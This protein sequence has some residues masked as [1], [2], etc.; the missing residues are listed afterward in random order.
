VR[1]RL[2]RATA[3]VELRKIIA[4]VE[5]GVWQKPTRREAVRSIA[6]AQIP[7][8]DDYIEYWLTARFHGVLGEKPLKTNTRSD[9]R[10]RAGHLKRFFGRYRLYEID[11]DLCLAF[12]THKLREAEELREA[13]RAGA[14]LRDARNHRLAPLG[15]ASLKKL[16]AMLAAVLEDAVEDGHL[17]ANPARSRRLRIRVPKPRRTF[18]EIDELACLEDIARAQ[19]PPL[20]L[21]RQAAMAA[22]TGSTR[23]A[24]A[25]A[26]SEGKSQ[27][28]IVRELGLAKGSVSYHLKRLNLGA[29]KYVGRGAI[30][31]TLG[32]SGVRVSELCNL[33]IHQLR[34]HDPEQARFLIADAKTETGVRA[35]EMS[36]ALVEVIL[37]H[38]DRLRRYGRSTTPESHLFQNDEGGRMR[39]HAVGKI[40]A[41]AA[42]AASEVTCKQGLPALPHT[43]PHSMRRTYI[44][45]ALLANNFDVVWVMKQVGHAN[46]KM[47]LEIYAQLQQR[48]RRE[49]G[50]KFDALVRNAHEQLATR[51][52]TPPQQSIGSAIGS[53]TSDARPRT[54]RKRRQHRDQKARISRRSVRLR[55]SGLNPG[56]HDFQ[57]CALPTELSR[58][59]GRSVTI[60]SAR[61]SHPLSRQRRDPR[62]PGTAAGRS[63]GRPRPAS[64]R[65]ISRGAGA[66]RWRRRSGRPCRAPARRRPP[67]RC[68]R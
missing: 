28:A 38:I 59:C 44:S 23:A 21:F 53:A 7:L 52:K 48:A 40:L 56:H 24:V 10:W 12:K 37:G 49:N 30:V 55:N 54:A 33:K 3:R 61:E 68:S 46:S 62:L 5:A 31:S 29:I 27:A 18:L 34:L 36:P 66:G 25:L 41:E 58:R 15:A 50:A 67:R 16:L 35:V 11:G 42:V 19:D 32:Y 57:S 26:A 9:Y 65:P 8:F 17:G 4:R 51:P 13:L 14:D 39:P 43:T 22:P 20:A 45:I 6:P 64:R 1:R 2:E 47:T 60:L 63:D